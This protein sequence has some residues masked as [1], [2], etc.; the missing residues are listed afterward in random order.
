MNLSIEGTRDELRKRLSE[1][2]RAH[3]EQYIRV[4]WILQ[5]D[6]ITLKAELED[7]G[8]EVTGS[9]EDL[10]LR[11]FQYVRDHPEEFSEFS[12]ELGEVSQVTESQRPLPLDTVRKWGLKF[13]PY[14][15]VHTFL[16]RLGELKVAY[17]FSDEDMLRAIPELLKGQAILWFRNNQS[18]WNTWGEF[19]TSFKDRYLP[20]DIDEV[21]AEEIRF[22]TQG[23]R[24]ISC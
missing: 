22:R 10:A 14:D 21:L 2:V 16:E 18:T 19:F 12:A 20:V 8:L 24:G 4:N 3:P 13:T 9:K 5:L 6:E 1:Y 15:S 23:D 7:C 17:R 11:L